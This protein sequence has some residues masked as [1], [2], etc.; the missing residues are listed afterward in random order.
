MK[1][2][3]AH[4]IVLFHRELHNLKNQINNSFLFCFK[5]VEILHIVNQI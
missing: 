3:L 4:G 2:K 1:K 5:D